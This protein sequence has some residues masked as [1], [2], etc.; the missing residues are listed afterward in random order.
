MARQAP[1]Y[2]GP[3]V[4]LRK[5]GSVGYIRMGAVVQ[6]MGGQER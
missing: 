1:Q 4:I 3:R 6:G 5:G 2:P